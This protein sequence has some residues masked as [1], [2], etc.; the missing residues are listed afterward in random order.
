MFVK[1]WRE[2]KIARGDLEEDV[3]VNPFRPPEWSALDFLQELADTG[4]QLNELHEVRKMFAE[5]VL[6]DKEFYAGMDIP[7]CRPK[8]PRIIGEGWSQII[9][10]FGLI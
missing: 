6:E 2:M 4:M 7:V 8:D 1:K 3:V 5:T 10:Q 9:S